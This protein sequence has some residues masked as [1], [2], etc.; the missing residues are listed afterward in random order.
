[1]LAC[2]P[3]LLTS[4]TASAQANKLSCLSAAGQSTLLCTGEVYPKIRRVHSCQ[5]PSLPRSS[6]YPRRSS[7]G[8]QPAFYGQVNRRTRQELPIQHLRHVVILALV[9]RFVS[10]RISLLGLFSCDGTMIVQW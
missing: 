3:H 7:A 5:A 6:A 10:L 2:L 4:S 8:Y 1:M 9:P